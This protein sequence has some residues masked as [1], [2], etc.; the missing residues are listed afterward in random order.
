MRESELI[1]KQ[2]PKQEDCNMRVRFT[3]PT[4]V[5]VAVLALGS[6]AFAQIH[7]P[8]TVG[9]RSPEAQKA[10]A[11]APKPAYE[12]HDLSGVWWARGNSVLMG[13]PVPEMTPLGQ[14]LLDANKPYTGPRSVPYALSNDPVGG[15]DPIGYPRILYTNNRSFDFIQTPLKLVQVF[16]WTHGS[17]EIWLDGRKIP[18][19]SDP[20]WYG[21]AVGHWDGDTLVVDSGAYNEKTWLDS[22]G[23][24]HSEDMTMQERFA[25]PD[26]MTVQITATL[27]DPKIYTK[28]WVSAKPQVYKLQLPKGVTEL[29][30]AYCVPSEEGTF[31]R[32]VRDAADGPLAK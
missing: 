7:G 28:P 21:Y 24:P 18:A 5:L 6:P 27:T 31:N 1:D 17:R 4:V 23:D 22:V 20:R 32:L 26:A 25:H 9:S 14:K 10:A 30:E 12:P 19:D 3:I 8:S 2:A 13:N 15:C 11:A 16:E 29:E